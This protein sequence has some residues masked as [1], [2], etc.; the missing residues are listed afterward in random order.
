MRTAARV[1]WTP[2]DP[3]YADEYEDAFA[4]DEARGVAAVADGVASAIFS[5]RWAD[6][7]TR[8]VVA[9][10][11]DVTSDGF[12]D[13]LSARRGDWT[14]G[15]DLGR[16]SI[17]QR[18][19]LQQCGGAFA[20]LLWVTWGPAEDGAG[21][22]YQAFAAGDSGLLHVRDGRPLDAFP[23]RTAAELA[24]DP[25]TICSVNLHKDHLL[26]FRARV[27]EAATGD[28]LVLCTDALLGWALAEAEAG[29]PPDW[30]AFWD[31]TA[32]G[33]RDR[34]QGLRDD[35]KIRVDDTTLI[36]VRVLAD[37]SAPAVPPD[38]VAPMPDATPEET[39]APPAPEAAAPAEPSPSENGAVEDVPPAPAAEEPAHAD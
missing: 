15:L 25:L 1:F 19:K 20:T 11:P 22:R 35:R 4:L 37:E 23:V 28:L 31:L 5:R 38:F 39:P 33:F 24:G 32:D 27:G 8:A 12:W 13:W 29:A 18:G 26:A 21:L 9:D 14:A 6:L 34:I 16:L 17:F 36:L 2:K 3:G 7:L 10:P 30:E